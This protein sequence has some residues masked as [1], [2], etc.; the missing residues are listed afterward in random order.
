M[1]FTCPQCGREI[2]LPSERVAVRCC[3]KTHTLGLP[4]TDQSP[5][6]SVTNSHCIHRGAW[7]N[8][9]DCGCG[10]AKDIYQCTLLG[11]LC[12]AHRLSKDWSV[13]GIPN[14]PE[15]T[16]CNTC[17][18]FLPR[19]RDGAVVKWIEPT[20]PIDIKQTFNRVVVTVATG[21]EWL[22]IL[23]LTG[24]LM[25]KYANRVG[26]DF[27]AITEAS[28]QWA[29]LEKFRCYELLETYDQLLFLDADVVINP[30]SPDLFAIGGLAMRDDWDDL[31][32][33]D[34]LRAEWKQLA[35]SHRLSTDWSGR[36]HNSGV[37]LC[38]RSH[39][40]IFEPP[41]QPFTA[42]H[43]AEQLWIEHN[44]NRLGYEIQSLGYEWNCQTWSSQFDKRKDSAH[45]LHFAN[46]SNRRQAIKE[47]IRAAYPAPR[48]GAK[49]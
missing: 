47:H 11:G 24:P 37:V 33:L 25:R 34:W 18:S 3:G 6:T 8:Q 10:D 40:A 42:T 17:E 45:V 5:P 7:V 46:A 21:D 39:H 44:A 16:P 15:P 28:Q 31:P 14:E 1:M 19:L 29:P 23:R 26:A 32:S 4:V 49:L 13:V 43:C 22:R 9:L 2:K 35:A 36:C 48:R 41:S 20:K 38:D 30:A 12:N 27:H